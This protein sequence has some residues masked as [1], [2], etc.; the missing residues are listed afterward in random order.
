MAKKKKHEEHENLERWLVSYADFIT[1]LFA[2]FVVL[3]AL[4]QL[5]LAKFK[6]LKISL[7]QAFAPTIFKTNGGAA[8]DPFDGPKS[9][10]ITMSEDNGPVSIMPQINPLLDLPEEAKKAKE[11]LEEAIKEGEMKGVSVKVDKR[12]L[13]ISLV[14]SV[15][16]DSGSAQLKESAKQTLKKVA[17]TLK[18]DFEGHK[19]RIEGHT[20][21]DPINTAVYPSNWEL[22]GARASA[23]VRHLIRDFKM[24]KKTF[25]AVGYADSIPIASN[26]T[27][28]GKQQ[29]RRVEIVIL[30][31]KTSEEEAS[32][33]ASATQAKSP[34]KEDNIVIIKGGRKTSSNEDNTNKE[35]IPASD[36]DK[37]ETQAEDNNETDSDTKTTETNLPHSTAASEEHPTAEHSSTQEVKQPSHEVTEQTAPVGH[38]TEITSDKPEKHTDDSGYKPI[39]M[40]VKTKDKPQKGPYEILDVETKH[41]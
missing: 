31:S 9:P 15:F 36:N 24:D 3:Y 7:Q 35:S 18:K 25:S 16:F 23:I 17:L 10:E 40:P 28:D 41:Y 21:S 37:K 39:E 12:G 11:D 32:A 14:N 6:D 30:N 26:K 22:S 19:I 13:V 34:K 8:P 38:V 27:T 29:N 20:D 4:S 1:L 5:D 33:G 2:V